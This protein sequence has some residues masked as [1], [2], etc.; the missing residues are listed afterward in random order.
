MLCDVGTVFLSS[1]PEVMTALTRA[2]VP[3]NVEE[4]TQMDEDDMI[5]LTVRREGGREGGR[6]GSG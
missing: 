5:P 3:P 1:Q 4:I 2:L 6:E